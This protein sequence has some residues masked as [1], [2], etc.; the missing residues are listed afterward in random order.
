MMRWVL[1]LL[2]L[3][4]A[5]A[6]Q[7]LTAQRFTLGADIGLTGSSFTGQSHNALLRADGATVRP[8]GGP[9]LGG[10]GGVRLL[11]N[12][13]QSRR[14]ELAVRVAYSPE[15]VAVRRERDKVPQGGRVVTDYTGQALFLS[16]QLQVVVPGSQ[17]A[18]FCFAAGPGTVIRGGPQFDGAEGA[19]QTG[20]LLGVG[21]I[22]HVR[23]GPKIRAGLATFMDGSHY[24]VQLTIGI[25]TRFGS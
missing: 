9:L 4:S 13:E 5:G 20:L 11:A 19:I 16:S 3:I 18:S 24:N 21:V 6:P 22:P 12:V 25:M 7:L 1:L 8:V 10:W 2:C 15:M 14:L 23:K 17:Q